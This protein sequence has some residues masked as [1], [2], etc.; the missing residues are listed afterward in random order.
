MFPRSLWPP[1]WKPAPPR[2][3]PLTDDEALEIAEKQRLAQIALETATQ[4]PSSAAG[5][6]DRDLGHAE[7]QEEVP[8]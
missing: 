3:N 7:N 6:D 4:E 5:A 1:E 8:Y 2:P